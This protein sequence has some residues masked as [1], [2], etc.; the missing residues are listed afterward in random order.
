MAKLPNPPPIDELRALGP[1]LLVLAKGTLLW[2]I[3]FRGGRFPTAWS[4]FRTFGP[5]ASSRFDHHQA[6]PAR[7]PRGI[8]HAASNGPTCFAEVFQ[9]TRTVDRGAGEPWLVGFELARDLEL[10]D[11]TGV[12]PTRAGASTALHSGRRDRARLWSRALYAAYPRIDGLRYCSSM[13]ANAPAFAL[14]ERARNALPARPLFHRALA[15]PSIVTV[16]SN[17]AR[18]FGY[19]LI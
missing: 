16:V 7:P 1:E 4:T 3:Y 12:W 10:H 19:A 5:V 18:Q 17:A 11:L 6:S 13:A 8:L 14:Y 9:E 2:R 15:D